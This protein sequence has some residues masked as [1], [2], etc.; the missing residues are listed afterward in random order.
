MA[1]DIDKGVVDSA[2]R[3]GEVHEIV[4]RTWVRERN[5]LRIVS[6][7]VVLGV[8]EIIA[9]NIN[10]LF[11]PTPF[12]V[13]RSLVHLTAH[14]G[15]PMATLVSLEVFLIGFVMAA[16]LGILAGL[17][18]GLIDPLK[19]FAELWLTVFWATPAIA[20]LPLIVIWFGLTTTTQVIIVFLST[21][22]PVVMETTVAVFH[23]DQ[24]LVRVARAFGATQWERLRHI[25]LPGAIPYIVSGLRIAVGRAVVG[26]IV[27]EL[28]TSSTGLG[29]K[30]TDYADYFETAN[31]FAVLVVFVVFSLVLTEC[32]ALFERRYQ[33]SRE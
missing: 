20:L 24:S 19:H 14:G 18:F 11:L 3:A 4:R 10:P 16:A 29:S 13:A 7:V 15:L 31:Y 5:N 12:A 6:I 23:V 32:V 17:L 25:I 28:F 2:R 26:V 9:V 8:W 30:M 1:I 22:F 27:A 21:F 33:R